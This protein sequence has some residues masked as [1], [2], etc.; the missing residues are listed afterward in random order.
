MKRINN[1]YYKI[2][3]YNNLLLADENARKNKVKRYGVRI[4]DRNKEKNLKELQNN[5]IDLKYKTSPYTTF[6]I[7]EPKEREIFRLPYY[8][9]RITHHALMNILEPI[10][11]KV[12]IYNSYSCR[13]GKGIHAAVQD[14]K[15]VLR[16]D[17][18][19]T[20]YCLKLDIRKFY[21]SIDHDVLKTIIRKKIKDKQLLFTLDEI[22]DSAPGVP[23]GNYLSQYFAN[24]YLTYF[25]HWLKEIKQVK[26][27]FRYADDMVI[28]G[29]NKESL[30]ELR[31]EIECYLKSKLKLDIK[32]NYQ[33]YPINKRGI[34]F[35][36]YVF[37]HT[38][39]LLRKSIKTKMLRTI[40][41]LSKG[42]RHKN[43]IRRKI[44]TYNGWMKFCNS[45]HL[46]CAKCKNLYDKYNI[47]NPERIIATPTLTSNVINK[48]IT[49]IDYKQYSNYF[50]F[51]CYINKLFVINSVS[52]SLKSKL[53]YC[54]KFNRYVL[55]RNKNKYKVYE[56]TI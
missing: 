8:P 20:K 30:H 13:K 29:S 53:N 47:V 32:P 50:K 56:I 19:N 2:T 31:K 37:F 44:C 48:I 1:I 12:F 51:Y 10:W 45:T 41:R 23:I 42:I 55:K 36:G 4:H 26:Y 9:D 18:D 39:T 16:K 27:Y 21:P 7:Y 5:L 24:L 46:Y 40:T 25:D 43:Y 11:E 35:V 38:H 3:D 54:K 17:K 22:I 6:K 14:I 49:I 52:L 33:V 15:K 34:D 28:F